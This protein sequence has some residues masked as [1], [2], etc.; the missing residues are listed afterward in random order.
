MRVARSGSAIGLIIP[1]SLNAALT[2]ASGADHRLGSNERLEFLGDAILGFVICERLYRD[3]PEYL[4][5]ELTRVKSIV[6]S[7]Q[8]CAQISEE[9]ELEQFLILGK[10][11]TTHPGVPSSVLSDVFEALVAAIYLDGGIEAARRFIEEPLEK[12]IEK[13][14]AGGAGG[15]YKSLLQ[16]LAQREFNV[17][18]TYLLLDEKGPDHCKCFKMCAASAA[19]TFRPPGAAARKNRNSVP[20]TTPSAP[21]AKKKSPIPPPEAKPGFF[22]C[23]PGF[24]SPSAKPGFS[25]LPG[26]PA[27]G[28]TAT[29][30]RLNHHGRP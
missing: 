13:A 26:R 29:L 16:Q 8:T 15:N 22:S 18:P 6:V 3:H 2:H 30:Q 25:A 4:E 17:T 23:L 24:E 10:G 21:S 5:G 12:V 20:P 11:M 19:P 7:R 9:L 14:A 28:H 1:R 27:S